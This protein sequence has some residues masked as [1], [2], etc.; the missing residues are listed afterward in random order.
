MKHGLVFSLIIFTLIAFC[1]LPAEARRKNDGDFKW[2]EIT[3]ADW[4][5]QIDSVKKI[6]DAAY[7]FEKIKAD[8]EGRDDN[9]CFTTVYCR[10]RILNEDGRKYG[11]VDIPVFEKDQKLKEIRGRT[12]LRDGT[13]IELNDDHIFEKEMIKTGRNKIKQKSFSMPGMTNDCIIEYMYKIQT[14]HH[15]GQWIIQEDIPIL[16]AVFRWMIQTESKYGSAYGSLARRS[17]AFDMTT[18]NYLMLNRT[19]DP[20]IEKLPSLKECEEIRFTLHDVPPF[21][22]EPFDLPE[23]AIKSK[24]LCYYGSSS[25]PEAYW[26]AVSK[27]MGESV[28]EFAEKNKKVRKVVESFGE[29]E[30]REEKIATAYKWLQDSL[31]N[32]TYY[33]LY[34]DDKDK[35]ERKKKDP[36][37]IKYADD[38]IKYG[39]GDR[40]DINRVFCDMLREMN[41]EAFLIFSEG[42]DDN[43]FVHQAKYWQFDNS[44]VAVPVDQNSYEYYSPGHAFLPVGEY[45]WYLGGTNGMMCGG[46]IDFVLIPFE[47][48]DQN[49]RNI[50][51]YY[52]MDDNYVVSGN[53]VD[54]MTGNFARSIR[55]DLYDTDESEW[56]KVVLDDYED[57]FVNAELDSVKVENLENHYE[58]LNLSSNIKFPAVPVVGNM[59][60]IKPFEFLRIA[61]NPFQEE[62]RNTPIVFKHAQSIREIC[63]LQIPDGWVVEGM[64]SDTSFANI[65][66]ECAVQF[67]NFG[68]TLSIQR[69][70]TLASPFWTPDYYSTVKEFYATQQHFNDLVIV[71]KKEDQ[72]ETSGEKSSLE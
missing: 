25:S 45:P 33:D 37:D 19:S 11:D 20:T 6:S 69:M 63:Q 55:L 10:I 71:L 60:I 53:V 66:G 18:P 2:E 39:Y 47:K 7:I 17:A 36:N 52:N 64:P 41:V 21:E 4:A 67:N 28:E 32:L 24:L 34:D 15:V 72:T 26:G 56:Q 62:T 30:T 31:L 29:L 54:K 57:K 65:V 8:D 50:N 59:L 12:I 35:K 13:E 58:K 42:R 51:Y 48:A 70:V 40:T 46:N 14:E 16:L 68:S 38:V 1:S 5:V 27:L 23:D 22:G 43:L 9:E 3:D 61:D 44:L 49:T